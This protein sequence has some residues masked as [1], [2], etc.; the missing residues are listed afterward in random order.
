MDSIDAAAALE[1]VR[2]L[3]QAI[4]TAVEHHHFSAG[5][6]AIEQL[7]VVRHAIVDEHHF[8]ALGG[9]RRR[10]IGASL[11]FCS[12][13]MP[14]CA[15][16]IHGVLRRRSVGGGMR[17]IHRSSAVKHK[18]LLQCQ[19]AHGRGRPQRLKGIGLDCLRRHGLCQTVPEWARFAGHQSVLPV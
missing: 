11:G 19:R 4:A 6:Q 1:I 17:H 9:R 5:L 18:A 8:L 2:H 7:L 3:L 15:G 14:Q 12:Q 16:R 13:C 10:S